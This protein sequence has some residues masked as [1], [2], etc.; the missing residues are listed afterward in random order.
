LV[1]IHVGQPIFLDGRG[2]PNQDN[3]FP[4]FS[5]SKIVFCS[6]PPS[7][8]LPRFQMLFTD[9]STRHGG[10]A[11]AINGESA[12]GWRGLIFPQIRTD[13]KSIMRRFESSQIQWRVPW[14]KMPTEHALKIEAELHRE[15]RSGH[16]LFG[17]EA[18]AVG[19]RQDCDDTLFYLGEASPQFAVVHLTWRVE[20]S[21]RWPDT[22][23]FDSLEMWVEQ[24]MIPDAEDFAS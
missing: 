10:G 4:R 2:I 13:L 3:R 1:R 19:R 22:T 18:I 24:C 9:I 17:R 23:L 15:T 16:V 12:K 21:P 11:S 8:W 14:L 20:D 6:L 7:H 5:G